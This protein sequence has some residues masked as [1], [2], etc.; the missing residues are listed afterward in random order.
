MFATIRSCRSIRAGGSGLTYIMRTAPPLSR[1]SRPAASAALCRAA[2]APSLTTSRIRLAI[3][4]PLSPGRGRRPVHDQLVVVG[5]GPQHGAADLR[6]E[7][8]V[9]ARRGQVHPP[10]AAAQR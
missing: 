7:A 2:C 5:H 10:E 3:A 8:L 9:G 1:A 4:T 6:D